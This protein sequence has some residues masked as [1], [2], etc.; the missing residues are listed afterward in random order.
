[1]TYCKMGHVADTGPLTG[2]MMGGC[3]HLELRPLHFQKNSVN[4]QQL[5]TV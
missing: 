2:F 5:C 3:C 1:M 4:I